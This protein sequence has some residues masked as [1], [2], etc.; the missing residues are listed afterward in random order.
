MH[1]INLVALML[2]DDKNTKYFDFQEEKW[3]GY[4]NNYNTGGKGEKKDEKD[5]RKNE[6]KDNKKIIYTAMDDLYNQMW[7]DWAVLS[8]KEWTETYGT[9]KPATRDEIYEL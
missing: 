7:K 9:A 4:Y 3:T 6:E 8:A 1:T 5:K 2:Q